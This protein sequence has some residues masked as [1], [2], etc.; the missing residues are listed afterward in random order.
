MSRSE[1]SVELGQSPSALLPDDI[2]SDVRSAVSSAVPRLSKYFVRIT[3]PRKYGRPGLLQISIQTQRLE[4]RRL[5]IA[6][7]HRIDLFHDVRG[8]VEESSLV[9]DRNQGPLGTLVLRNLKGSLSERSGLMFPWKV[10]SPRTSVA[11]VSGA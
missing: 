3:D 8:N 6:V 9:L 10:M 2:G 11:A 5:R 7:K 1:H 4:R